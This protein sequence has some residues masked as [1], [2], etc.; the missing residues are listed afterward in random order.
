MAYR[1]HILAKNER[2]KAMIADY[3]G[4]LS[5]NQVAER[6]GLS[7]ERVRVLLWRHRITLPVEERRRRQCWETPPKSPGRPAVWPDCPPELVRDYKKLRRC[8]YT[9]AEARAA[10]EHAA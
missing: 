8:G 2:N 1:P 10:L 6:Y 4:G 3:L 5:R 7:P 9:A